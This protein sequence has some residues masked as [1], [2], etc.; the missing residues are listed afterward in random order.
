MLVT[1]LYWRLYFTGVLPTKAKGIIAV[2]ENSY[3]QTFAYRIDGPEVTFLGAGDPHLSKYDYME[4]SEDVTEQVKRRAGPETR[5]Y[6]TVGLS[7]T[8]GRYTLR[9]Y[10]SQDTEDEYKSNKPVIYTLVVAF[11]FFLTSMV[12]VVF[13]YLVERR[14][15]VVLDRAAQSGALVSSLFPD[16]VQDRLYAAP[17][18]SSETTS[19]WRNSISKNVNDLNSIQLDKGSQEQIADVYPS[20]TIMFADLAGFTQYV[21]GSL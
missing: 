17:S 15:R 5:A 4:V 21:P 2:L 20:V 18:K 1:N 11:I 16:Q 8:F 7:D 19:T 14:Q 12:F 10:P 9:V 6:T 13:D 3:N